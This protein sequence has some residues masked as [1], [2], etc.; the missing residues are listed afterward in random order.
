MIPLAA[1]KAAFPLSDIEEQIELGEHGRVE[2]PVG[3]I[4]IESPVRRKNG[5]VVPFEDMQRISRFA[6]P[7]G[8]GLH[9]DGA[10]LFLAAPYTGVTPRQSAALFDTVYV[11]VFKY[12][13]AQFGAILAGP[14]SLLEN[15]YHTRRTFGGS[16]PHAWA[17]AVV[18]MH[19]LDGFEARFAKAV[20]TSEELL[21]KLGAHPGFAVE[22]VK[23]GSNVAL[24]TVPTGDAQAFVDR[25]R[26]SGVHIAAPRPSKTAGK[27]E[28]TITTNETIVRRAPEEVAQAFFRAV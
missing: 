13:N 15:L 25:L 12:F 3:A 8:I 9:L 6:R 18:A 20:A 4:S 17:E 2:L 7:R 5:E 26:A 16:V 10:R 21:A 27:I 28:L 14:R 1:G 11:S 23:P 22:R 19:Y 24:V